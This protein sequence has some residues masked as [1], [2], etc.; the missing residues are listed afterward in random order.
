M[1]TKARKFE[2][3][4]KCGQF[5][6]FLEQDI[7]KGVY[8]PG[9]RVP[10]ERKLAIIHGISYLTVNKALS[11]LQSKGLLKKIQ[12]S[13]T[14]VTDHVAPIADH[15][16]G[17]VIEASIET[18]SLFVT[19]IPS[20]LQE[21]GYFV[22]VFDLYKLESL[23]KNLK[24]FLQEKPAALIVDGCSVFPFD[25]LDDL[26]S[27]TQL[28]FIHRF[29]GVER[30]PASYIL[31]DYMAG[32]YNVAKHL[33]KLGRKRI[34]IDTFEPKPVWTS[35]KFSSG[36]EK[37]LKEAGLKPFAY[38]DS[39]L[40]KK[41]DWKELLGGRVLPDAVASISDY[42]LVGWLSFLKKWR[43]RVPEDIVLV[44]YYNTKWAEAYGLTSV[45][46]CQDDIVKEAFKCLEKG[47]NR[48]MMLEPRIV[49]R[50]SCPEKKQ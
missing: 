3:V 22:P 1:P 11:A 20:F 12:G 14:Y 36:V 34:I 42:T 35:G 27:E 8:L 5:I 33:L 9:T 46:I 30:Y 23:K 37:A 41:S 4:T 29:E 40:M 17:T 24:R 10:S 18:H 44:G 28:I 47:E 13:G 45:S 2:T 16:V 19:L 39:T 21:H 7:R 38:V 25:F 48:N 32:G 43:I 15:T 26:P 31:S 6:E 49:F 50:D